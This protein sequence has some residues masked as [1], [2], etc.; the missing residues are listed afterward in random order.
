[1]AIIKFN[2]NIKYYPN[3]LIPDE[4]LFFFN[5]KITPEQILDYL[6]IEVSEFD[7]SIKKTIN[8]EFFERNYNGTSNDNSKEIEEFKNRFPD[9]K[10]T[11]NFSFLKSTTYT[12]TYRVNESKYFSRESNYSDYY[13][14]KHIL[15]DKPLDYYEVTRESKDWGC[16]IPILIMCLIML[17]LVYKLDF[18]SFI[19]LLVTFCAFL[20]YYIPTI[21]NSIKTVEK[22]KKDTHEYDKELKEF[23]QQ[24]EKIRDKCKIEF[25]EEKSIVTKIAE[26]NRIHIEP[27]ILLDKLKPNV[28]TIKKTN[29]DFR[30]KS[31]LFFLTKL[32]NNFNSQVQVD[33]VPNFG[34]NPFQPDFV[35]IC[36]KTGFHID[37][38]IDEPY[39]VDNGKPIHHDRSND[40]DRNTFFL[41]MNWAVIR[42]SE[43]QII[44]NSEECICFIKSVLYSISNK[45]NSFEHNLPLE[46]KWTYE[47]ALIMSNSN[48][49]N[50]YLPNAMKIKVNY[51][52]NKDYYEN[53]D[54]PF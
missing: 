35:L 11:N 26:E 48:Y 18:N 7:S 22:I 36:N 15:P 54:L 51:N 12:A 45:K 2:E 17:I 30:G 23:K 39:S 46:K 27:K 24:I 10:V 53:D 47:E 9:Y 4:L 25:I 44:E 21:P 41:E 37:I 33:V 19:F 50:T 34:K 32:Y 14:G 16:F 8:R 38:E 20:I 31:E 52:K 5:S 6:D 29:N 49:R 1:M 40:E 13:I 3:V 43:K 42:F 28:L